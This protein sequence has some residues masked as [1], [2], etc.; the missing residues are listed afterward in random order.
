MAKLLSA[1]TC[2]ALIPLLYLVADGEPR[3][4]ITPTDTVRILG[5]LATLPIRIDLT[6]HE[7][8]RG[9]IMTLARQ[10]GL[11]C[12]DAA[13]LELAMREGLAITTLDRQLRE[14]ASQVGVPEFLP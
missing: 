10:E 8:A 7:R 1:I 6:S 14:A 12:Y 11:T 13:Y 3:G 5:L 9:E 2:G 4:R